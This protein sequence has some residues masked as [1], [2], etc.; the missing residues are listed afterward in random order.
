MISECI[1]CTLT[2]QIASRGLC[3]ACR[4]RCAKYGSLKSW[5]RNK[6]DRRDEYAGLRQLGWSLEY[7]AWSTGISRRTGFRYEAELEAA[8]LAPWR[9]AAA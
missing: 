9:A 4:S 2:R 7:A 5:G 3:S 1:C 8:G 6:A